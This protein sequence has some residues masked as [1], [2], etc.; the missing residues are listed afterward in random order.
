MTTGGVD[1]RLEEFE[2]ASQAL[3]SFQGLQLMDDI[4][5]LRREA[6]E[7]R[8]RIRSGMFDFRDILHRLANEAGG[9]A[10]AKTE[11]RIRRMERRI[12]ETAASV[13]THIEKA[14][15]AITSPWNG[16]SVSREFDLSDFSNVEVDCYFRIEILQ[17][18]SYRVSLTGSEKLLDSLD[19]A[20]SGTGRTLKISAKPQNFHTRPDLFARIEMPRLHKLRLSAA[21]RCSVGRFTVDNT[22]DANLSG[23]SRLEVDV[24]AA[25]GRV[26][27]S[28]ASRLKGRLEVKDA[29]F[30]LSGASRAILTGSSGKTVLNAWGYSWLDMTDFAMGDTSVNLNAASQARLNVNGR[31]DI[32]LGGGSRLTYTGSPQM[33]DVKV[34][35]ASTLTQA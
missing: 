5:E 15:S 18:E 21:A 16:N 26:E 35:G 6:E 29:E 7:A 13:E 1:T 17:A 31:L 33:G 3:L 20:T 8:E 24:T 27:I 34:T 30:V 9:A 28:G 22:F 10:H 11:D 32:D 2:F 4:D 12:E 19:V 25:T 14:M 23:N